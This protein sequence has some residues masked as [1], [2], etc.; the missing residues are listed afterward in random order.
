ML[1]RRGHESA[2][3]LGFG[4]KA[5]YLCKTGWGGAMNNLVGKVS[6]IFRN[7]GGRRKG[8]RRVFGC[9]LT[10]GFNNSATRFGARFEFVG[11][12][13]ST[14]KGSSVVAAYRE[15]E[16]RSWGSNAGGL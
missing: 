9:I 11:A 7:M 8:W 3:T 15:Y 16:G 12:L 13:G 1:K 6:K 5:I 14:L 2:A 4:N 10:G